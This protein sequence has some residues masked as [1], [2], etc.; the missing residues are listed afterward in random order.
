MSTPYQV[1][2][3]NKNQIEDIESDYRFYKARDISNIPQSQW[4]FEIFKDSMNAKTIALGFIVFIFGTFSVIYYEIVI[5]TV[6]TRKDVLMSLK[7]LREQLVVAYDED[8]I[9][10]LLN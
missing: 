4:L 6:A 5:Q 3:C 2:F 8:E 10:R 9:I 1:V 7:S